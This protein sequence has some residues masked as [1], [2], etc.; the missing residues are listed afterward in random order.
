ML[1][2]LLAFAAFGYALDG[3]GSL[4]SP[5]AARLTEAFVGIVAITCELPFVLYLVAR[6]KRATALT[7]GAPRRTR[8]TASSPTA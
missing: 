1:T 8:T 7:P 5:A 2:R 3:F 6:G 4:V